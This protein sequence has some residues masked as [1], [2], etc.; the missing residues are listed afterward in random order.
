[1]NLY[2]LKILNL[3]DINI[4]QLS[5]TLNYTSCFTITVFTDYFINMKIFY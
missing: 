5:G 3:V 2:I 1:M 4:I